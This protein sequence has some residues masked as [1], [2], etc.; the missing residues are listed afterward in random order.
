MEASLPRTMPRLAA[1][2]RVLRDHGQQ[3]RY[4]HHFVGINSRLDSLQAAVLKRGS[5]R[6]STSGER[7]VSGMRYDTPTEFAKLGIGDS[8][9][10]PHGRPKVAEHVWNQY[11]R[12]RQERQARRV[13]RSTWPIRKNRFGDFTIPY[14]STCRSASDRWDT[15]QAASGKTE[16]ACRE[17]LSLPIYPELTGGRARRG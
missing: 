16:Q 15:S 14:R 5:C 8:I 1:K 11:N 13:C 17:V 12:A 2:L 9:V 6:S 3:P 7:P 10:A 4:Y